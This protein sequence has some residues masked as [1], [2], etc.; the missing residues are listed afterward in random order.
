[1]IKKLFLTVLILG[2]MIGISYACTGNDCKTTGNVMTSND[3]NKGYIFTYDCNQ[4]QTNVG[5]WV[6]PSSIPELKGDK[7]DAG[8][9]GAQGVKGD[10][11]DK[12]NTGA[13]GAIG[14]QGVQGIKGDKGDTGLTGA[15]GSQGDKGDTGSQGEQGVTGKDGYTPIKDVDYTDGKDGEQGMQ[16]L[17][18]VAGQVGEQGLQGLSGQQGEVGKEGAEGKQG[19]RG[20][21]GDKGDTGKGLENRVELIGEVRV[22]DTRKWAGYVYGGVDINNNTGI[23]GIK[24]QY[25]MGK[26]YEEKRLDELERKINLISET[27]SNNAELY[28]DGTITGIR[29]KF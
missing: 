21:K 14:S 1:M 9:T 15:T 20:E 18:G 8:A 23:T 28:T 7:G 3:G 26:S 5:K 10:K 25:K 27:P 12:G 17:Q 11:G 16:G 6:D 13:T 24:V 19:Q 22:F 29:G 4:G 2:L